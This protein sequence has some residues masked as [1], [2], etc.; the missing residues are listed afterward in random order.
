[1]YSNYDKQQVI[2]LAGRNNESVCDIIFNKRIL[3]IILIQCIYVYLLFL[4]YI[5]RC[6]INMCT[7]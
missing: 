3:T 6:I 7:L 4:D 5:K 2:L 1:M